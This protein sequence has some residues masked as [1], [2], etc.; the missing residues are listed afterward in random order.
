MWF[1]KQ[2]QPTPYTTSI[3]G[4]DSKTTFVWHK[5]E[6]A[7]DKALDDKKRIETQLQVL[8]FKLNAKI[9]R[10]SQPSDKEKAL[11][12][13]M[14]TMQE[15]VGQMKERIAMYTTAVNDMLELF[16]KHGFTIVKININGVPHVGIFKEGEGQTNIPTGGFS[17]N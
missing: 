2:T 9:K 8:E 15:D 16:Q 11:A 5:K 1:R 17:I 12:A 13:R 4:P 3:S 14:A 10:L 7:L 6:P